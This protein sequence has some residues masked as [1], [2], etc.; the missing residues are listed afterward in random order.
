MWLVVVGTATVLG[1]LSTRL[2]TA[3][4][5]GARNVPL[6]EARPV[7]A[8]FFDAPHVFCAHRSRGR[9]D[10]GRGASAGYGSAGAPAPSRAMERN[11]PKLSALLDANREKIVQQ[12]A[13]QLFAKTAS[14]A[15]SR[16]AVINSLRDFIGEIAEG[17]ASESAVAPGGA[18]DPT[19]S[20]SIKTAAEHGEQRFQLGYDLATVLR[21]YDELRSILFLLIEEAA[22]ETTI[23]ELGLLAKYLITGV[24]D[25]G[26]RY[27]ARKDEVLRKTSATHIAFLAHELRNPISSIVLALDAGKRLGEIPDGK[28]VNIIRRSLASVSALI[29]GALIDLR[30]QDGA[31]IE[32]REINLLELVA[33]LEQEIGPHADANG[34]KF[35]TDIAPDIIIHGDLRIIQ[36]ALSNLLRNAIKFSHPGGTIQL[37]ARAAEG[38]IVIE[39]EDSCGGLPVG[40]KE[41]LFDPFVQAG[42]DRT[43][44]GLGLAIAKQAAT[45]HRGDVR[46]HDVPGHGCVFVLDL[47]I[48]A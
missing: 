19:A 47:P 3:P 13:D 10:L 28:C 9:G 31:A 21:E 27:A 4:K 2:P 7:D 32:R 22:P 26:A 1:D 8:R 16:E 12:F 36:S 29:D 25:A 23:A 39:V 40:D 44:F 46:V 41:K 14:E 34:L 6:V 5:S 17:F 15:L 38:R 20:V 30:L 43:G 18:T 33:A 45:A 48:E 37:R 24:A 35:T 42:K 11:V